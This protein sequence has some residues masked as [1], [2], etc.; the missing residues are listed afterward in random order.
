MS[1]FDTPQISYPFEIQANGL[2]RELEQDSLDEVAMS[3]EICLRYPLGYRD[4][5]P[6]FGVP[7]LAFN[8]GDSDLIS[9]VQSHVSRWE[10]R[11]HILV[12]E[13]P[14]DWE[15]MARDLI[16]RVEGSSDA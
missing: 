2:V 7:E 3:V 10:D 12:E 11:V 15:R 1:D 4:E 13:R 8:P 14:A 5:L 6:E 16:V 9:I